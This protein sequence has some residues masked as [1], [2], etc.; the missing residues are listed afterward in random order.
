MFIILCWDST[1]VEAAY[2]NTSYYNNRW[3]RPLLFM[4]ANEWPYWADFTITSACLDSNYDFYYHKD[5]FKDIEQKNLRF[6]RQDW[7]YIF[8]KI[9]VEYDQDFSRS[10][11]EKLE[12]L[13]GELFIQRRYLY[14]LNA[15]SSRPHLK[16][17]WSKYAD[18]GY[19]ITKSHYDDCKQE[20][21]VLKK[22]LSAYLYDY[23][24]KGWW[25][26]TQYY[27][28]IETNLELYPK[29]ENES[30]KLLKAM[31][32]IIYDLHNKDLKEMI[33]EVN[34]KERLRID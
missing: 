32:E 16:P 30:E 1:Q 27:G 5:F 9:S 26:D 8:D 29:E 4:G 6:I 34:I 7:E 15:Q 24:E 11:G 33:Y 21:E 19:E 22:Y 17:R 20:L 23:N 10:F 14:K 13:F 31:L 12:L 28:I 2:K 25:Q 3:P 18:E